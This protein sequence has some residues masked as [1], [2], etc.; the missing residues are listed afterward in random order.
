MSVSILDKPFCVSLFVPPSIPSCC[1]PPLP[2]QP[3]MLIKDTI[4]VSFKEVTE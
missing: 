1:P 4:A 2:S 3:M